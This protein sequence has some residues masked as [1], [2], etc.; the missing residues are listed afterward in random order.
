[1]HIP[2]HI[3]I[4]VIIRIGMVLI[5]EQIAEASRKRKGHHTFIYKLINGIRHAC[6]LYEILY[7]LFELVPFHHIKSF[8][9]G[10]SHTGIPQIVGV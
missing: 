10:F 7:F 1:M 3:M 8:S 9:L 6:V 5:P 2:V 4:H